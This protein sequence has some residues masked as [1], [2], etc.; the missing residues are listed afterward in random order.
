MQ[1]L[2]LNDVPQ[3]LEKGTANQ[4]QIINLLA[5]YIQLNY[6]IFGLQKFDEDFRLEILTLFLERGENFLQ[7]YKQEEGMFFSYIYCFI[8]CLIKT[9]LRKIERQKLEEQI[10]LEQSI[11]DYGI[12]ELEL[13]DTIPEFGGV[14]NV[15]FIKKI[16]NRYPK[17]YQKLIL[18]LAL[19]SS[20]HISEDMLTQLSSIC[21]IEKDELIHSVLQIKNTLIPRIERKKNLEERRNTAY[22]HHKKYYKQ[23]NN[24]KD[25]NAPN[26]KYHMEELASKF[27]KQTSNW[28]KINEKLNDGYIY[29][30]PTNKTIADILG[31]CER[32]VNYYIKAAKDLDLE[33]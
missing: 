18:I 30:R 11:N 17:K 29:L 6:P 19:K 7:S 26:N 12:D 1:K 32:Q 3:L 4:K 14:L 27:E 22:F 24:L 21:N 33:N 15:K 23:L 25:S 10:A 5:E 8:Q 13:I 20:Y 16:K 9:N 28:K 2:N 31:I